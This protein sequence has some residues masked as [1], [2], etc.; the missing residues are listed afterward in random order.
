MHWNR[1]LKSRSLYLLL[2]L[3]SLSCAYRIDSS[4]TTPHGDLIR[5]AIEQA[6][7]MASLASEAIKA[8]NRDADVNRLLK[9]LFCG[10]HQDPATLDLTRLARSL[11]GILEMRNEDQAESS[12]EVGSYRNVVSSLRYSKYTRKSTDDGEG[13]LL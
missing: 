9:L 10:P 7:N 1:I 8:E 12:T 11:S 13:L 5:D 2:L 6:F 3:V 4:C